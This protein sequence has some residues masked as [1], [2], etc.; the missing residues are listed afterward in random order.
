MSLNADLA[1]QAQSAVQGHSGIEKPVQK[2]VL[3]KLLLLLL[4]LLCL[5]A[6]QQADDRC[7]DTSG[8]GTLSLK[9]LIQGRHF[10]RPRRKRR[11]CHL[12]W[13]VRGFTIQLGGR[14]QSTIHL[15]WYPV[16]G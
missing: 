15:Y 1:G 10:N 2:E 8:F 3:R 14:Y 9:V 5:L 11:A 13:R 12:M 16:T 6:V 7:E 4:L